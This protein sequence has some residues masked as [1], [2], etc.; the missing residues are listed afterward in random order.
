MSKTIWARVGMSATISD[1]EYEEL[2]VLC[3]GT[4]EQQEEARLKLSGIFLQKGFWD[5]ESYMPG[6]NS[7]AGEDNPN[8]DEF[9]LI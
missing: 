9:D 3:N 5:G 1:E 8:N 6:N 7:C 2:R 4:E